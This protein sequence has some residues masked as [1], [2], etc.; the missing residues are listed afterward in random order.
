MK[1]VLEQAKPIQTVHADDNQV[2]N[3][4]LKFHTIKFY[5]IDNEKLRIWWQL[6]F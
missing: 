5:S 2:Q 6:T 3:K 4:Q 1:S